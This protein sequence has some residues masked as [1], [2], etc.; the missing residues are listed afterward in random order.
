MPLLFCVTVPVSP[1]YPRGQH[2]FEIPILVNREWKFVP[3]EPPEQAEFRDWRILAT[4]DE[5]ARTLSRDR[6]HPLG[7][8]WRGA[9]ATRS[10]EQRVV[11][12]G[13]V[14]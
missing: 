10:G 12:G 6:G 7:A 2:C 3:P 4:I 13:P 9:D 1:V 8:C 5:L 14:P 11:D